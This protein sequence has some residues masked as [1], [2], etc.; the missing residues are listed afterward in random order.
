LLHFTLGESVTALAGLIF[1]L[2]N[3]HN[4]MY[5]PAIFEEWKAPGRVRDEE[6]LKDVRLVMRYHHREGFFSMKDAQ[7]EVKSL[8]T[9][10]I[11][12]D[13]CVFDDTTIEWDGSGNKAVTKKNWLQVL[14]TAG[15]LE[16]DEDDV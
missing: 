16:D 14:K 13:A 10:L 9:K 8:R 12:H 1:I 7:K 5:F 2:H 11:I 15:H 4:D 3:P 6:A